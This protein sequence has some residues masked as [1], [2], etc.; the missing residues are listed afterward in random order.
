MQKFLRQEFHAG[1]RMN[2]S[3]RYTRLQKVQ[4]PIGKAFLNSNRQ[5]SLKI[6]FGIIY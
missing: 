1:S 2:P 3:Q 4:N 6:A 5:G